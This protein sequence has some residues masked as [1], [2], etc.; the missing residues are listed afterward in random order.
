MS[1]TIYEP[2][3][4]YEVQQGEAEYIEGFDATKGIYAKTLTTV[5]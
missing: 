1:E 4:R 2:W 3:P 5:S